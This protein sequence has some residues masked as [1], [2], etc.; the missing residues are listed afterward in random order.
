[1]LPLIVALGLGGKI[2][3]IAISTCFMVVWQ[4]AAAGVMQK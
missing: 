1:L 4:C 2:A 3:T